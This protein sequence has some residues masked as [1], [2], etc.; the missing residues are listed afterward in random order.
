[1]LSK[2]R[3]DWAYLYTTRNW[4]WLTV[5]MRGWTSRISTV[6]VTHTRFS[7]CS[8]SPGDSVTSLLVTAGKCS[9]RSFRVVRPDYCIFECRRR[10]LLKVNICYAR[11]LSENICLTKSCDLIALR[12]YRNDSFTV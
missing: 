9:V 3:F 4:A 8:V 5:V 10:H 12:P 1:M 11:N 6:P 7:R 2:N